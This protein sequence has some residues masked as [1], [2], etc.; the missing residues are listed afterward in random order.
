MFARCVGGQRYRA[1]QVGPGADYHGIDA[2]VVDELLPV[3]MHA[4]N[5]ELLRHALRRGAR[6]V[7]QRHDLDAFDFFQFG[8]MVQARIAAGADDAYAQGGGHGEF[9]RVCQTGG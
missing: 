4:C 5:A 6:A 8:Y 3:V 7:H 9:S 1:M 2:G